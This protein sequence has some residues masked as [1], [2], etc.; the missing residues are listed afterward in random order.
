MTTYTPESVKQLSGRELDRAVELLCFPDGYLHE[1]HWKTN[2]YP[3]LIRPFSTDANLMKLF[4]EPGGVLAPTKE[5]MYFVGPSALG[6][7]RVVDIGKLLM[8]AFLAS[9]TTRVGE[10]IKQSHIATGSTIQEAV[11]RAACVVASEKKGG[12]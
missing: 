7:Y 2:E 10:L 12:E 1:G 6:D 4:F 8:S 5:G 9:E 3:E 11:A